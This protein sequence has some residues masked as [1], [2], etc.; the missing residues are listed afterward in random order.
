MQFTDVTGR[1]TLN[2]VPADDIL[3]RDAFELNIDSASKRHSLLSLRLSHPEYAS[4][5]SWGGLQGKQAVTLAAL[6]AGTATVIGA[7]GDSLSGQVTD[8]DGKAVTGALAVL[9]D[10]TTDTDRGPLISTTNANGEYEFDHLSGPQRLLAIIAPEYPVA[11]QAVSVSP[12]SRADI[13]LARGIPLVAQ[14]LDDSGKPISSVSVWVGELNEKP[15]DDIR[16]LDA[17]KGLLPHMSD[18]DGRFEWLAA[19][20]DRLR[21]S[22]SKPGI[23]TD[24]LYPEQRR[25]NP[26][27]EASCAELMASATRI[28]T[29]AAALGKDD[30]LSWPRFEFAIHN[31]PIV[32]AARDSLETAGRIREIG[33]S[34]DAV[35]PV[36]IIASRR[37]PPCLALDSD[38]TDRYRRRCRLRLIALAVRM[39]TAADGIVVERDVRVPMSD[40]TVLRANV[41]RRRERGRFPCLSRG[42]C[43]KGGEVVDERLVQAGYIVVVQDARAVYVGRRVRVDAARRDA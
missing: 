5:Y 35:V 39:T 25:A 27:R 32:R 33:M 15:F 12:S 14:F 42:R 30:L 10:F 21:C 40:G 22:C 29:R 23:Q 24:G 16:S 17:V 34:T 19:P 20:G 37:S 43:M 13:A 36:G 2:T 11:F 4:D 7:S 18:A 8:A 38:L 9:S 28:R 6:R 3:N 41:F 26:H 1:W 31:D